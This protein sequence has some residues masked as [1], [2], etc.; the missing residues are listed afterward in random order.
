MIAFLRGKFAVKNPAQ[1]IVDV[2]GVGYECQVSLNTYSA[3]SNQD[4]GQLFTY[5]HITENNQTFK[6]YYARTPTAIEFDPN[7]W[8]INGVGTVVAAPNNWIVTGNNA[9]ENPMNWSWGTVPD[10]NNDVV[11]NTG[12]VVLSSMGVCRSLT[13]NSGAK[14]TINP[15]F[16]LKVSK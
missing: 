13:T 10:A 8:I 2:N 7:H 14:L 16:S 9:W 1:V 6:V 4:S 5:L 3:I 12:E 15:G 11:I